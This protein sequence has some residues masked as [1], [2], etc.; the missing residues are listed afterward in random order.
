MKYKTKKNLKFYGG[1]SAAFAAAFLLFA[2]A[3]YSITAGVALVDNSFQSTA[4]SQFFKLFAAVILVVQYLFFG[5]K[6]DKKFIIIRF[7]LHIIFGGISLLIWYKI[8]CHIN[9]GG[10]CI[11][12]NGFVLK[13]ILG[14]TML[15]YSVIS[16]I[17]AASC[18]ILKDSNGRNK[19]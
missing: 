6:D 16:G 8:Y 10:K 4:L 3:V 1:F 13:S 17:S 2:S 11:F 5:I 12:D 14:R 7:A 9:V 15:I 18:F 19:K